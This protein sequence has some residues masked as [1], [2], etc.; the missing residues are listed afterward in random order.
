MGLY[1]CQE[2]ITKLMNGKIT[3]KNEEFEYKNKNY[4]GAKFTIILPIK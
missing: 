4:I 2:I 1:M 3:I